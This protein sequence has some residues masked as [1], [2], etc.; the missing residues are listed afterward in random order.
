MFLEHFG[1]SVAAGRTFFSDVLADTYGAR[2]S[3]SEAISYAQELWY[4]VIVKPNNLSQWKWIRKVVDEPELR[5][6][7]SEVLALTDVYR[8]ESYF[9]GDDYRIVVLD[10]E[11]VSAYQRIPLAVRWDGIHTVDALLREKVESLS[12]LWREIR[13]SLDDPR[14]PMKLREYGY[15][16]ESIPVSGEEVSL[17]DNANLSTGGTSRDVTDIIHPDYRDLAIAVTRDMW[18]RLCGV[19][20]MT[21]GSIDAPIEEKWDT[22]IIEVNGA[23]WL[24]H[25]VSM[26]EIQ[27]TRA[28]AMYKKILLAIESSLT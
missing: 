22:V 17:L 8:I 12:H 5:D 10:G 6:A 2:Y 28:K 15:T 26:G 25:Y 13:L 24:D 21:R 19:D 14:I 20:I 27:R 1:Y 18:L 3:L 11:I 23:P 7:I 4:P 9:C 16:L